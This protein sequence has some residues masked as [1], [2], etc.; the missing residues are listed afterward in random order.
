M[1]GRFGGA[2][3]STENRTYKR[4]RDGRFSSGGGGGGVRQAL[5]DA[6]DIDRLNAAAKAETR[7]I[8][9]RRY[10]IDID[11]TGSDLQTAK[12]HAEG[13]L[14]GLEKYP[15]ANLA[16]VDVRQ[17][18]DNVYAHANGNHIVF[19]STFA[20]SAGRKRYEDSLAE[21]VKGWDEGLQTYGISD[22]K[23]AGFHTRNSGTPIAVGLHEFGHV[24]DIAT[25]YRRS[26]S[27][28]HEITRKLTEREQRKQ[29]LPGT[30]INGSDDFVQRTV[31]TYARTNQTELI[32]EAFTDVM[33]NGS[34]ASGLSKGIVGAL[35]AEYNK[36]FPPANLL[37]I[38][39]RTYT[40]DK[41]GRFS[42]H[43]G[44][45]Q[46]LQDAKTTEEVAAVLKSE[47]SGVLG[48]EVKVG[49]AGLDVD[50][51]RIHAEGVLR[52]A[53]AF[54]TAQLRLVK[55]YGPDSPFG[56]YGGM[57][58]EAFA[59]TVGGRDIYFNTD[60]GHVEHYSREMDLATHL[61]GT[62]GD[63]TRVAVH[64]FGHVVN[65]TVPG[66]N[67]AA[68]QQA[69]QA[70]GGGSRSALVRGEI[71][72]YASK[73]SSELFAEAFMDVVSK[74]DDASDLS[75][76]IVAA[77][78][79]GGGTSNRMAGPRNAA[80]DVDLSGLQ[81]EFERQLD[82]LLRRWTDITAAQRAQIVDQ[83]RVA[84]TSNDLAALARLHVSTAEA[85]QTLTEAMAQIA[86][87]AARAMVNEAADQGVRIDPVASDTAPFMAT[88]TAVTALLAEG[89][90]NSGGRE[91]LRLWSPSTSGEQVA[92]AVDEHLSGLSDTFV[93]D[94][95]GGAM[96]AALTAGRTNTMLAAPS[97]AIY[98]SEYM[99]RNTCKPCRRING[100]WLGNSDDPDI[101]AKIEAVYPNGGYRDCLGGVR[102]RGTLISVYRPDQV[103]GP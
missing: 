6:K 91:A 85:A 87:D 8:T 49:L 61:A 72:K 98:A 84:V 23:I 11:M 19:N 55:T 14:R 80:Q 16:Q 44:I 36:M 34:G 96:M 88:A 33:V 27:A 45:R 101:V 83:V 71:S 60:Y 90:T 38:L 56:H 62:P 2:S 28:V 43:G 79:R 53:E 3:T 26:D 22:R 99:D 24:V 50:T 73:N 78:A 82:A 95:L 76:A 69:K 100:K 89:L 103:L 4:D 41:Q 66:A 46:S 70:T 18:A 86:L 58:P 51:A 39:A 42:G 31:S 29:T 21:S 20:S 13:I 30:P 40:R 65:G 32:A 93:R 68:L 54:P 9:G 81:A 12:E 63:L 57:Q 75:H 25:T 102:C 47:V 74:G 92:A 59:V 10:G 52:G 97:A 48:H 7:R 64:E 94:N 15:R 67:L 1:T 5:A 35:D 37:A 77:A 17:L